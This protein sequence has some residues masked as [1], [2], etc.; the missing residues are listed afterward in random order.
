MD[1][2]FERFLELFEHGP[3]D[4][5]F[6][7]F[8]GDLGESPVLIRAGTAGIEYAFPNSGIYIMFKYAPLSAVDGFAY[9]FLH[10]HE[11]SRQSAWRSYLLG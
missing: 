5:I 2:Q 1:N 11:V 8:V 3:D 6:Q 10:P 9:G 4:P 7:R